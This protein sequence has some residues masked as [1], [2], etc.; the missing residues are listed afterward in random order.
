VGFSPAHDLGRFEIFLMSQQDPD[1]TEGPRNMADRSPQNMSCGA[2]RS[3]A[4]A[5]VGLGGSGVNVVQVDVRA[6]VG[7]T[8][9]LSPSERFLRV[10]HHQDRSRNHDFL[11]PWVAKKITTYPVQD[12]TVGCRKAEQIRS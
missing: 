7:R 12:P 10:T 8:G 4:P 2:R 3:V 6:Y 9:G 5:S 11:R 1:M